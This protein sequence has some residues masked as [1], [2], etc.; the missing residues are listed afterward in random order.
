MD[1][2][3]ELVSDLAS[4]T[5]HSDKHEGDEYCELDNSA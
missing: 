1:V 5:T 2:D 4:K 3:S